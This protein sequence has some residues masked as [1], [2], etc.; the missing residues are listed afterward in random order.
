[1]VNIFEISNFKSSTLKKQKIITIYQIKL[2][3]K[4]MEKAKEKARQQQKKV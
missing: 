1:M 4:G 2:K 3:R